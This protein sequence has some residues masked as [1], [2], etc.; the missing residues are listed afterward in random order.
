MQELMKK[1]KEGSAT[2]EDIFKAIDE[3][4]TN[5]ICK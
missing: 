4:G 5:S 2:S 1:V 3:D